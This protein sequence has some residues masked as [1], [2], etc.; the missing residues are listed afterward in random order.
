[1]VVGGGG[2]QQ[3][4]GVDLCLHNGNMGSCL[5]GGGEGWT[6][7]G[8]T[9][10]ALSRLQG[11]QQ[12]GWDREVWAV[13]AQGRG[14][15]PL[16]S[17]LGGVSEDEWHLLTQRRRAFQAHAQE[18]VHR[19][20]KSTRKP[21]S[22]ANSPLR[23]VRPQEARRP[24]PFAAA[25][26]SAQ[27]LGTQM[28]LGSWRCGRGRCLSEPQVH[29]SLLCPFLIP[30]LGR[31]L[32]VYLVGLLSS[33]GET[34]RG[35]HRAGPRESAPASSVRR[36]SRLEA[37]GPE[38]AGEVCCSPFPGQTTPVPQHGQRRRPDSAGHSWARAKVAGPPQR[39]L[40]PLTPSH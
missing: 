35:G 12:R 27:L 33:E 23:N 29:T 10:P 16:R 8:R 24:G 14:E 22:P 2:S 15:L 4:K 17:G 34:E 38:M 32:A 19:K 5:P 39:R 18:H 21:G 7:V 1:M 40:G 20:A 13:G 3:Q 26:P 31:A 37:R 36:R 30:L 28:G 9:V 25:R 11:T 6:T